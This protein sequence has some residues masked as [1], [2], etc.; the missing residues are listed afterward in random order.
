MGIP[1]V[2]LVL[3]QLRGADF[4]AAGAYPG[5][6]RMDLAETAAAV[7]I[8]HADDSGVTVAVEILTPFAQGGTVCQQEA[9]RAMEV[10]RRAGAN[11]TQGSCELDEKLQLYR[12]QVLAAFL[13]T[14]GAESFLPGLGFSVYVDGTL[15]PYGTAFTG[16]LT[17][18]WEVQY[19]I[20][21]SAPLDTVSGR[22]LWKIALEE[23]FPAGISPASG[24]AEPFELRVER[25]GSVE[26]YRGCR[27]IQ[28]K[29]SHSR[30]GL[31]RMRQGIAL[32]ME[33]GICAN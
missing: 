10:L 28:E 18:D 5:G 7:H 12:V 17:A 30:E 6:K 14:A 29:R 33:D 26:I 9:L 8:F 2:E 20:G 1:I 22:K 11:C 23:T 4:R 13:G 15:L 21:R 19:E 3:E 31:L 27:W 24:G 25:D 16:E 32:E